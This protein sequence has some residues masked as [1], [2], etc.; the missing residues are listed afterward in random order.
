M[1]LIRRDRDSAALRRDLAVDCLATGRSSKFFM[2]YFYAGADQAAQRELL[3]TRHFLAAEF[4][5]RFARRLTKT[6]KRH[7]ARHR[8]IDTMKTS[9]RGMIPKIAPLF[10]LAISACQTVQ[11]PALPKLTTSEK[12]AWS[13]Y[14]IA[15][16]KGLGTC[17]I[18]NRQDASAPGGIVPVLVTCTHVLA[19]AP[20]GPYFLVLR[21]PMPGANP[22]I[23]MLRIDIP[24]NSKH[25]YVKHPRRDVAA[26][27]I[28]L[29][30]EIARIISI[31]SFISESTLARQSAPH[32]G[33]EIFVLGFPKVF[34]GTEGA[35][36]VFRGG[37]IA[38]YSCGS[39]TDLEKYLIHTNVY[40]GD[41]GGPVF[42]A[43]SRGAPALLG[44]V[45]ER[46]GP[47]AGEVP[48]AVAIDST[49]IRETLALL[50]RNLVTP[51]AGSGDRR[52]ASSVDPAPAVKLVGSQDLLKKVIHAKWRAGI[53]I[54]PEREER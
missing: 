8:I 47:K 26:M 39:Q 24:P 21:M 52:L 45:T 13:T 25:P 33:D 38:S 44:L 15:T 5:A 42:A 1:R 9:A 36:P 48:L 6:A 30:S 29:P 49:V 4:G 19:A 41:S 18:V 10:F 28:Q 20:R 35:F 51:D 54:Q 46:I 2:V 27:E 50:P 16:T 53:P 31:P 17:V 23:V 43:R 7:A 40:S 22:E 37:T 34:P 3:K 11:N 14:A 12:M 32:V